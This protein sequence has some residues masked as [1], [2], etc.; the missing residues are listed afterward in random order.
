[1]TSIAKMDDVVIK[2]VLHDGGVDNW[3]IGKDCANYKVQGNAL[4]FL[5]DEGEW[6]GWYNLSDVQMWYITDHV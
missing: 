2:V 3:K 5:G 1:M 4:I 6:L